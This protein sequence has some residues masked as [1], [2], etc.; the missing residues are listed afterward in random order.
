[1]K[2]SWPMILEDRR[3]A[4]EERRRRPDDGLAESTNSPRHE[5]ED[6]MRE[7]GRDDQDPVGAVPGLGAG[8]GIEAT[9]VSKA[10]ARRSGRR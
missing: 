8:A 6:V 4:E 10:D 5:R 9:P 2:L 1:M 7:E 3:V